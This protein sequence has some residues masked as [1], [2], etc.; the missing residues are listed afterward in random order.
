M[1]FN[2]LNLGNTIEYNES[3]QLKR[4]EKLVRLDDGKSMIR[5]NLDISFKQTAY[6]STEGSTIAVQEILFKEYW[7][8][9]K[10]LEI[11]NN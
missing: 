6:L 7:N 1:W 3:I 5:L 11:T 8:D 10:S 2:N 4:L 9:I